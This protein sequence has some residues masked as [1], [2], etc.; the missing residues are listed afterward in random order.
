MIKK[1]LFI[2]SLALMTSMIS[3]AQKVLSYKNDHAKIAISTNTGTLTLKPLADNAVRMVFS[4]E[5]FRVMPELVYVENGKT[6]RFSVK[7]KGD[8]IVVQ[9]RKMSVCV[10]K[11]TGNIRYLNEQGRQ[12]LADCGR[13]LT[14]SSLS[15]EKTYIAEQHFYSPSDEHLY[16]LGQFQDGY[17]D[18]RGL[19]RRLTQVNTQISVPFILSNKGYALLWNNYGMTEFNPSDNKLTLTR[20]TA[21]K[22]SEVAVDVT[23]TNGN[24]REIR[25][26][27][28]FVATLD[29]AEDGNYALL[30]DVSQKMARR[31]NLSVDGKK[32]IDMQNLWLPPTSSAIARL[33]KGR[34]TVAAELSDGDSPSLFYHLV[35][36]ETVFRSPV[37]QSV[38][39][40]VF[41]GS[42]DEAIAAY[43]T[44]TGGSPMMPRWAL[45]YIHCRE[46]FNTQQEILDIA[47]RFKKDSIPVDALVQ[48]WQYW[49]KY[50]WN[51]MK[52][53]EDRY[54]D[55][56]GMTDSL[57]QMKL[58]LMVS[59]W[60]N[61]DH[62][63]EWGKEMDRE[64]Y[65]IPNTNWIDFFNPKA[66]AAYWSNFSKRV[67]PYNIDAWWQDATEPENDDLAGRM[68]NAGTTP[69]EVFRNTYP[70][71]VNK[72]VYEGCRHECPQRRTMILT[73]CAFPG[74]QR[75]C[76]ANWSGDVGNDWD[77]FRRQITAGLGFVASGLPWWTYDAGG[78]FRPGMSQYTDTLYHERM[79]RWLQTS[80]FMPLMRVHGYQSNT[81]FWNYGDK[82]EA[83]AKQTLRLRYRFLSYNY[84]EAAAV[85]LKGSTIMRPLIMDFPS[86]AEALRQNCEYM[87]GPSLLISPIVES[88]PRSWRVYLPENK[89]GWYDFWN[90]HLLNAGENTVAVSPD[91]IPVFVK[92]GSIL[93]LNNDVLSSS[94][95]LDTLEVR[96][97]PGADADYTLYQDAGDGY[98]YEKGQYATVR[99]HWDNNRRELKVYR[100]NGSYTGMPEQIKLNVVKMDVSHGSG[101]SEC[102]GTIVS[103]TGKP[104]TVR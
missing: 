86:D 7:E 55:V 24:K 23:S 43:R 61:T 44:V 14:P 32:L 92:A 85:S 28:L 42:A 80:A 34:H 90:G 91:Y 94:D 29:V 83:M 31:L 15:T 50:G 100:R 78:F 22:G 101:I 4:K 49:G 1:S 104:I 88:N 69:G 30:L 79:L 57:H 93:I 82:V 60:S 36:D 45:G 26:S 11:T 66:A 8:E 73:R 27:N 16:G 84:S 21:A 68:V 54:P 19:S 52:F 35:Q 81:E 5:I 41:A 70:L 98:G 77:T 97:Y 37:S 47:N 38:D 51:A 62:N 10:N 48:D 18:V 6:S 99:F 96:I 102:T 76:V 89:G 65:F 74:I 20:D 95:R 59:V 71:L 33:S 67:L 40:T 56:K 39:Y 58:H 25:R 87:F 103:Y 64:G 53:D 9:L 12:I 75:Y 63:T 3:Q 2:L 17:L 13:S 46:R 72:T